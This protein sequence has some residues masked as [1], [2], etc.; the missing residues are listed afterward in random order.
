MTRRISE[1]FINSFE[2]E[3]RKS[4]FELRIFPIECGVVIYSNDITAKKNSDII[5][6]E[7]NE[8]YR[9]MFAHNPGPMWIYDA[10]TLKFLDVNQSAQMHYGYTKDEFLEMTIKDVRPEEDIPFFVQDVKNTI[11]DYNRAGIWRHKKKNGDII[12]VEVTSHLIVYEA[13]K[14][15]LVLINDITDKLAAQ[16][17]VKILTDAVEQNPASIIITD[18]DGKIEYVNRHFVEFM[19]YDAEDVIGRFPRIFNIGH[20]PDNVYEG[21]WKR[22]F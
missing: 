12:Y 4:Y 20:L 16:E 17:K 2:V 10:E 11:S 3:G 8:S 22:I 6:A 9:E 7:I 13:R 15:R 19:Q 18:K 21:M 14:A 1:S 5:V